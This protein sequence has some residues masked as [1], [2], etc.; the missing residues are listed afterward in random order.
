MAHACA[1]KSI[2]DFRINSAAD[3][4]HKLFCKGAL[5]AKEVLGNNFGE[6]TSDFIDK[7][8][9]GIFL[10][11]H[12]VRRRI[13]ITVKRNSAGTVGKKIFLL[14]GAAFCK[15]DGTLYFVIWRK[16]CFKKSR[17][18][19]FY[20]LRRAGNSDAFCF[21]GVN[22]SAASCGNFRHRSGDDGFLSAKR[23]CGVIA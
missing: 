22:R 1:A 18:P 11:A 9:Q 14:C 7:K 5:P 4:K 2:A 10:P 16:L 15:G 12:Y 8:T 6:G 3:S 19:D 23:L 21:H 17:N 20:L 13:N